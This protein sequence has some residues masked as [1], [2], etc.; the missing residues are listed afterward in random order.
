MEFMGKSVAKAFIF[1]RIA[2]VFVCLLPFQ[3]HSIKKVG[4]NLVSTVYVCECAGLV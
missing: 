3:P 4:G 2:C 1:E